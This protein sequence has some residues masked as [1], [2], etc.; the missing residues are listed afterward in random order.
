MWNPNEDPIDTRQSFSEELHDAL[1]IH[2]VVRDF[3]G[4]RRNEDGSFSI[5]DL[6]RIKGFED[7]IKDA[8][9]TFLKTVRVKSESDKQADLSGEPVLKG[10]NDS[11][12]KKIDELYAKIDSL[13]K[14]MT[15][16]RT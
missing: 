10:M 15:V 2:D 13:P 12:R 11:I 16:P 3:Y 7:Y 6:E 9:R 5:V 4:L 14:R 8:L 1:L